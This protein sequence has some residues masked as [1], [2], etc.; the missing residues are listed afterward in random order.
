MGDNLVQQ[1]RLGIARNYS[2][3]TLT[4]TQQP[5]ARGKVQRGCAILA[6]VTEKTVLLKN[7]V[8]YVP[9]TK[10][11]AANQQRPPWALA[12]TSVPTV[13]SLAVLPSRDSAA[14]GCS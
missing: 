9:Q 12:V 13:R 2:W 1:A 8:G 5:L 11:V 6:A 10:P 7:Q 4:A 3:A 14:R